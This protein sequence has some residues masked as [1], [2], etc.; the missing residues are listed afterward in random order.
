MRRLLLLLMLA[1][2]AGQAWAGQAPAGYVVGVS[3]AGS[4]KTPIHRG[5]DWIAAKLMMPVY[6]GDV[7]ELH[8]AA[9]S[10]D[11]D[12][13]ASE[14]VKIAGGGKPHDV[15]GQVVT[16]DDASSMLAAIGAV[17]GGGEQGGAENMAARQGE[18]I[19]V[20]IAR[21]GTNLVAADRDKLWL[22]W[23]GGKAP[24]T[25]NVKGAA[26]A[27]MTAVK[28]RQI[29]MPLALKPGE[30]ATIEISDAAAG[31]A[32]VDVKA[33]SRPPPPAKLSDVASNTLTLLIEL[34]WLLQQE[35]G[36]WRLEAAQGLHDHAP[37][38]QVAA[39][40]LAKLQD[41]WSP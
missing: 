40:L 23:S 18:A 32:R 12:Q 2:G 20:A 38:Q 15:T 10:I 3:L 35:K 6:A 33:A 7:I 29:E 25:V 37:D 11:I 34:D 31:R 8:D 14:L 5:K 4:D 28:D 9:S 21:R 13:G 30:R 16:G 24:F 39:A 17:L 27:T 26:A 36:A 41:G 1:A 22:A 19:E